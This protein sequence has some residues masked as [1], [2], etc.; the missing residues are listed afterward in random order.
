MAELEGV[1]LV[2]PGRVNHLRKVIDEGFAARKS[3]PTVFAEMGSIYNLG[4][5]AAANLAATLLPLAAAKML[6][7][8]IIIRELIEP[9]LERRVSLAIS[10][11]GP[12]SAAA[13]AIH[14]LLR[15]ICI[16]LIH[17]GRW[18]GARL[19]DGGD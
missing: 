11:A 15:E 8:R 10:D 12:P 18:P 14:D 7:D 5:A 6:S 9:G 17:S 1:P 16:D 4:K 13:A 19:I 3:T 2:L